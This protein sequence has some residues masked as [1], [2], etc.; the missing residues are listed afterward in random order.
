MRRNIFSFLYMANFTDHSKINSLAQNYLNLSAH[1]NDLPLK[2]KIQTQKEKNE[3]F[4]KLLWLVSSRAG[5]YKKFPNY[6]DLMQD[7]QEALVMALKSYH[8]EKG[9][10]LTWAHYYIRTKLSRKANKHSSFHIPMAAAREQKPHKVN[11][12]PVLID[13]TNTSENISKNELA[14]KLQKAINT[15][16]YQHQLVLMHAYELESGESLKKKDVLQK[17][18]IRAREYDLILHEAKKKIREELCCENYK[19]D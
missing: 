12:L 1:E 18:G 6:E 9:N 8:P 13:D 11:E 17:C 4:Q 3:C 5:K 14:F 2:N 7:G 16:D 19:K 15:L 10:F